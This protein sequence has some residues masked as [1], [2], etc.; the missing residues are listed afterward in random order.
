MQFSAYVFAHLNIYGCMHSYVSVDMCLDT[1]ALGSHSFTLLHLLK[2]SLTFHLLAECLLSKGW[3]LSAKADAGAYSGPYWPGG[4]C[5]RSDWS[6]LD[7]GLLISHCTRPSHTAILQHPILFTLYLGRTLAPAST[8]AP[9][10]WTKRISIIVGLSSLYFFRDHKSLGYRMAA[11]NIHCV[12]L[13]L[14]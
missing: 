7:I 10:N 9:F 4:P 13:I 3:W 1:H 8:I 14:L 5:D 12:L 11:N 6:I 2:P